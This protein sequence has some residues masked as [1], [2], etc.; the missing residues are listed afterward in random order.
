M[1]IVD[2]DWTFTAENFELVEEGEV[3]AV[4]GDEELRADEPFYPALMLTEGYSGILGYRA[5][6]RSVPE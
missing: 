6:K 4:R 5:W 3:Y 2:G 1:E